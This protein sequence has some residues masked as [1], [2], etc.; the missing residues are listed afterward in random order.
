MSALTSSVPRPPVPNRRRRVRHKIQTPAYASFTGDSQ[1]ATLDLYEI[2]DISEE[3]LAIQCPTPLPTNSHLDLCLDLAECPEPIYTSGR[4]I[5]SNV[6]GRVGVR[7]S[8]LPHGSLFRLRE[9]LFL[10]AMAAVANADES[11]LAAALSQNVPPRPNYTDT[12]EAVTAVQREA[13]AF[14]SDLSGALQVVATRAQSLVRAT[15]AAIALATADHNFMECRA[16]A[17]SDAPPVGA[18]LQVGSGFSG[19][20]V[21]TG[22][23]LRCDDTELDPRVDR[24]SCRALG[25]RSILAVPIRMGEKSIGILEAFSPQPNNF[26]ENDSRVL[27][28]LAETVLAAVN[29][30][31]RFDKSPESPVDQHVN[32]FAPVPGSVLFKSASPEVRESEKDYETKASGGISLPRKHL[33]LLFCCAAMIFVVLGYLLAPMIQ[34]RLE[35]QGAGQ[36]QTV[37][38]STQPP[39]ADPVPAEASPTSLENSSVD[40]LRQLAAKGSPAAENALGL[41]YFQGDLK[42]GIPQDEREAAHWFISAAEHGSVAAQSKLG[43]LYWS[44]RGVPKDLSK[45]Y[46]WTTIACS[47]AGDPIDDPAVFLSKDLTQVLRNQLTR[48]Q[49][50]VIEREAQQWSQRHGDPK[51][52]LATE[53]ESRKPPAGM[54]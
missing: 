5:W 52:S 39:K 54:K 40:Q 15:G 3:G 34:A 23:L 14:G 24:E 38:A 19:E 4:V 27:Q 33:L 8:E 50:G 22:R 36:L 25:I 11:A 12:L 35:K 16:S 6:T 30:V 42:S 44:G 46:L 45:A 47:H 26:S 53:A 9:W 48:D 51:K 49:A 13:E 10:N 1:L 31:S 29:R 41:R 17:G 21:R 28:R 18:R 37:L 32:R 2:V 20:C 43:F 7:F